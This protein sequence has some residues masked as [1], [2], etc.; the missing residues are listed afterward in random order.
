MD[1]DR[2]VT[3]RKI[4]RWQTLW[5]LCRVG[6]ADVAIKLAFAVLVELLSRLLLR[7]TPAMRVVLCVAVCT[8][9]LSACATNP[10]PKPMPVPPE[11]VPAGFSAADCRVTDPG[12]PITDNSGPN[13]TPRNVGTRAP[14]VECKKHQ[15][16]SVQATTT[17]TCHTQGG[18]PLPLSD[19]CMN[20]D[21][22]RIQGCT[23]KQ[24]PPGE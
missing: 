18:K 1:K 14:K 19:C 8:F 4:G 12:G 6:A 24:Q 20:L 5:L 22:S 10:P 7:I 2:V 23:P 17:P 15:G 3:V 16:E 13:G 11:L 9:L 21:G